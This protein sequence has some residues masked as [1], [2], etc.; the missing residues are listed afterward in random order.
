M[1]ICHVTSAHPAEDGRIFRRACVS[2]ANAGYETY[3]VE[4]GESYIKNGVNIVGLNKPYSNGRLYR[5]TVYSLKAFLFSLRVNADL[6]HLHDPELLP[7]VLIYKLFGKAVVFDSHENY[8]EQIRNKEYLPT[9]IASFLSK[10][11]DCFSRVIFKQLDGLTYPG[12]AKNPYFEHLCKRVSKTDNLPWLN[13][14]YNRYDPSK[15]RENK[16]ACYIGGLDE[17]RGI[18]EMI[19]ASYKAGFKLYL[20]GAFS[21]E[22]Y[23]SK[24]QSMEEYACV[25]YL[26]VIGRDEIANLLNKVQIG[27]CTLLDVGQYYKM[28]NMPT[29]V[30]EYMSMGVPS[31]LNDSPYNLRFNERYHIG[32]CVNPRNIDLYAE[33]LNSINNDPDLSQYGE[34]GRFL[35]KTKYC[36]DKEQMNLLK[37]YESIF[38][39]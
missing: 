32:K 7:Y 15:I 10:A 11:F 12:D 30:Y 16:T 28:S 9:S 37:L 21:N 18:T 24:I 35:I 17:A 8:V 1:K 25:E 39:K 13:E 14:L 4:R 29:K 2:C 38:M 34:N 3:L 6:Y 31:I 20:A 33:T 5:M 23:K 26:G 19:Q 22:V 27:L 36:W